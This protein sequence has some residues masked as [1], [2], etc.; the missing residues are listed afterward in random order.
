MLPWDPNNAIKLRC[1]EPKVF[2]SHFF[3]FERIIFLVFGSHIKY[4]T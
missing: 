1:N 2:V 4:G 3:R